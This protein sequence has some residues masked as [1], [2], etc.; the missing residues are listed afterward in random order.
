M[1]VFHCDIDSKYGFCEGVHIES[2]LADIATT[3]EM[4][5]NRELVYVADNQRIKSYQYGAEN[6]ELLPKHT[7][8]SKNCGP[9]AIID[10]GSRIMRAGKN[11]IE[12]WTVDSLPNHGPEGTT[13]I[14]EEVDME[15]L[16]TWRDE[17][18]F[19]EYSTGTQPES[20]ISCTINTRLWTNFPNTSSMLVSPVESYSCFSVDIEAGCKVTRRYLG[21]GGYVNMFSTSPDDPNNFLTSCNDG[22][23]RLFDSR[24]SLPCLSIDVG[25]RSEP[26][27][28]S[29]Y[30]HVNGIPSEH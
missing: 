27:R 30:V 20:T 5:A 9:I 6:K 1:S 25:T 11:N 26:C 22:V 19:I 2:G 15:N 13:P 14:G 18:S 8:D 21:H 12:F 4:D 24:K 23:A 28:S 3:M 17:D 16:W 29:L 10:N 7:L